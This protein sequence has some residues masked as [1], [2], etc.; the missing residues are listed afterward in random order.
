MLA[1]LRGRVT[2]PV[3]KGAADLLPNELRA[4]DPAVV[5][6]VTARPGRNCLHTNHELLTT[7]GR[8]VEED[9]LFFDAAVAAGSYAARMAVK[10]RSEGTNVD[11]A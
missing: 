6:E 4:G 10:K 1:C 5:I 2:V 7:M 8:G 9:A 3:Y 11:D